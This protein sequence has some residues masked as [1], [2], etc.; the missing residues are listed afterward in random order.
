[1]PRPSV[2]DN[3]VT[4]SLP[5]RSSYPSS[6]YFRCRAV[7]QWEPQAPRQDP[8]ISL[9]HQGQGTIVNLHEVAGGWRNAPGPG[10][11]DGAYPFPGA[12]EMSALMLPMSAA[13]A[14]RIWSRGAP[15][16]CSPSI[17]ESAMARLVE[18]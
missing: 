12:P 18:F 9:R 5:R 3:A 17:R 7:V 2:P 15:M 1:M 6:Q 4:P 14:W 10:V 8:E 16:T 11:G 13:A